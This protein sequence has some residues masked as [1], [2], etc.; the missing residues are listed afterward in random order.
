MERRTIR[1]LVLLVLL[2]LVLV[3]IGWTGF[4]MIE[5][6][7]SWEAL[8]ATINILSAVGLGESPA[9][10]KAGI[11]LIGFL[12]FGSISIVTV[13]VA[14]LTQ[15]IFTGTLR[16][17]MGRYRMDE[18][19][20]KLNNHFIITGYSL[21]GAAIVKDLIAE[22]QPFVIIERDPETITM[23]EEKNLLFVEGDA[24]NETVLRKAGIERA[25]ALFAVLSA[26]SD[27]LM[28]VLSA[29]GMKEDL[30]VVSRVTREEYIARFLR[31]GADA[32][33]S[34]QEWASRRMVQSVLRP[35]L[36]ELL[37]SLLDPAVSH[38]YL[39]EAKVPDG[40]SIIGKT[41]MD[42]GI[43]QASGIVVLGI[44]RNDGTCSS[45]PGP[46]TVVQEGDVLLGY[47]QRS[48]F[49]KLNEFLEK[50]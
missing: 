5:G 7:Q 15:I 42:S 27:N 9:E 43:R 50:S 36:L 24:T 16:Q 22:N 49:R 6:L 28:V 40:S 46:Q 39:D 45:A 23:L 20:N 2:V 14:A 48:D 29:R 33:M 21:T 34:P 19:I 8:A 10:S 38:A 1:I 31:A 37:S 25:R 17:Y 47:G 30:T 4:M 41:L 11:F 3:V 26:D 44:A 32:A 35:H 12:Q 13:A 18:R